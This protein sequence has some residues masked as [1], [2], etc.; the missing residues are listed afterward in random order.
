MS[1]RDKINREEKR[2]EALKR[3][4][5]V[6]LWDEAINEFEELGT[7]CYS[8]PTNMGGYKFGAV[9]ALED[10]L[11][12]RVKKF[13]DEYH[14]FV[15]HVIHNYTE[16]GEWWTYLYVSDYK[17]EW[18]TDRADLKEGYPIAYVDTGDWNS[19]FG[20]VQIKSIAGGLL[21]VA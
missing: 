1:E 16:F 18:K 17:E 9:F 8:E 19:E 3:M 11:K 10:E 7:V 13:E 14:A 15:W 12:E 21:R 6:H 2:E 20:S 5:M 4:K